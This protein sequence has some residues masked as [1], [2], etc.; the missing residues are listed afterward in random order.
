M[1]DLF[2]NKVLLVGVLAAL[3]LV[4]LWLTYRAGKR[5]GASQATIHIEPDRPIAGGGIFSNDSLGAGIG[6]SHIASEASALRDAAD[7]AFRYRVRLERAKKWR[8]LPWSWYRRN[9]ESA[10]RWEMDAALRESKKHFDRAEFYRQCAET[11]RKLSWQ[12]IY[13]VDNG[14]GMTGWNGSAFI[15][16]EDAIDSESDPEL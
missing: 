3:L 12:E 15:A 5:A 16:S 9:Q 13:D 6:L 10:H 8:W 4:P 14:V 1:I 2:N 11:G 7:A